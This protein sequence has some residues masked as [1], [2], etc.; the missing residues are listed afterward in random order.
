MN[1]YNK[2]QQEFINFVLDQYVKEG[3]NEL[4][5]AKLPSILELKYHGITDAKNE[6]GDIESIRNTFLSFQQ[7][8][9]QKMVV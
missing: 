8:L 4:D 5:D 1:D 6:L 2:E 9:Y 3:V 7:F